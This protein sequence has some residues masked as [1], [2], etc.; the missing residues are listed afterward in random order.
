MNYLKV[1]IIWFIT[2]IVALAIIAL[3]YYWPVIDRYY[4]M[5]D[6]Y[7]NLAKDCNQ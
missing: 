1:S 3:V 2:F 4:N 6:Y 7:P 5:C